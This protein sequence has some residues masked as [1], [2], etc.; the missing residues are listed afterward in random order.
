M[1]DANT[2]ETLTGVI[3]RL[4]DTW[5]YAFVTGIFLIIIL[6]KTFF[7]DLVIK[8]VMNIGKFKVPDAIKEDNSLVRSNRS[9]TESYKL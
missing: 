4:A 8:L 9:L 6:F 1:D 7:L 3:S 5:Y 2:W